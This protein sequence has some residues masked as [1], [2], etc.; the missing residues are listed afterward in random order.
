[1]MLCPQPLFLCLYRTSSKQASAP[2][3]R[4]SKT[5][6]TVCAALLTQLTPLACE[7]EETLSVLFLVMLS[8]RPP[9]QPYYSNRKSWIFHLLSFNSFYLHLQVTPTHWVLSAHTHTHTHTRTQNAVDVRNT[10]AF[11]ATLIHSR[12]Q[13]HTIPVVFGCNVSFKL[14]EIRWM[15]HNVV[16]T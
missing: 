10:S 5:T 1:M 11:G 2:K 13:T 12:Q 7:R 14:V 8:L 3:S 4:S 15:L 9:W 16:W 6:N